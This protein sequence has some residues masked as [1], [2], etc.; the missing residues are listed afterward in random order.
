MSSST[1][2]YVVNRAAHDSH[3]LLRR[4]TS[5]APVTRESMTLLSR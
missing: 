1:R 2:S 5:P 3:S 4:V